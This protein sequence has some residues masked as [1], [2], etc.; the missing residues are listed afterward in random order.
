MLVY[1]NV[2]T[3]MAAIIFLQIAAGSLGV[4]LPL[5]MD[6]A[7]WSAV[8]IGVVVA[9]Y[10]A[11]FMAGAWTAPWVIRT[12]GHIRAYAAYAGGAAAVTLML[13]LAYDFSFWTL[14][15]FGFGVCAAGIFAVSE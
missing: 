3:V 12:I 14:S 2:A 6:E 1:R 13:A 15:R 10:G 9:A 4:A 7:G 11:G 8:A 5:A